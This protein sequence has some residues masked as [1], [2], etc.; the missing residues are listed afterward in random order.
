MHVRVT[1][2]PSDDEFMPTEGTPLSKE[3]VSALTLWIEGKPIPDELAQLA[4]AAAK[5]AQSAPKK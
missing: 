1:L 3:Q 5:G 2:D 4:L